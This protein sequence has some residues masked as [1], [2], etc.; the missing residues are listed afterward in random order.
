MHT[1]KRWI[2]IYYKENITFVLSGIVA[3]TLFIG[4]WVLMGLVY[5]VDKL[6]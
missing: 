1:L 4:F 5:L 3:I 2:K 6:L